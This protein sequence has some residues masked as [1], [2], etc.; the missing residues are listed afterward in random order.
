M[1]KKKG[2]VERDDFNRGAIPKNAYA[3]DAISS[4]SEIRPKPRTTPV[5]PSSS[6]GDELVLVIM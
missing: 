4:A 1:P 2:S 6:N 5:A 3:A